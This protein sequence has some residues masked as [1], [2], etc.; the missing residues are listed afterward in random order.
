SAIPLRQTLAQRGLA[1]VRALL[2]MGE[3]GRALEGIHRLRERSVQAAE[4]PTLE[5]A[6][7]AWQQAREHAS[8][9]EFRPALELLERIRRLFPGAALP[10]NQFERDLE[11]RQRSFAELVL[12]LHAVADQ[13]RWRDAIELAEQVLAAAPNHPEAR[14][15]KALAWKAIEPVTVP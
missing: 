10:L 1:E 3:P 6:A 8:R 14:K 11:Q 7:R 2:Q 13:A 4:L 15:V 5:D 9:G 12:Q